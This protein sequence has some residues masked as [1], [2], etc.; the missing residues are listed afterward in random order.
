[1]EPCLS[2]GSEQEMCAASECLPN[3]DMSMDCLPPPVWS[4]LSGIR[5]SSDV[6][7]DA[8]QLVVVATPY[9]D[10]VIADEF[11]LEIPESAAIH[12]ITVEVRRSSGGY[13]TDDS[14]RIVNGGTIGG[15]ER[16]ENVEWEQDFT[17]ATYGGP[18][19]SWGQAWTADEVNAD[20][21]GVAISTFYTRSV[22]NTRAYI[23]QVRVT[24]HYGIEC[25]N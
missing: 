3:P 1:M 6:Q 5:A 14:V 22:G 23:D 17:W 2:R 19:D 7:A 4:N 13:V 16:A 21:F 8:T 12:G 15:A 25:G 24:I 11:K 10:P 9:N 20:D 18:D